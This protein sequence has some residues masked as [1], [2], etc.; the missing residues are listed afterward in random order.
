MTH[1]SDIW[2]CFAV[3]VSKAGFYVSQHPLSVVIDRP[4]N[5]AAF[6]TVSKYIIMIDETNKIIAVTKQV[7][8]REY[9]V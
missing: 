2:L 1:F 5:Q 9:T 4:H 7:P 6:I 8:F 3:N